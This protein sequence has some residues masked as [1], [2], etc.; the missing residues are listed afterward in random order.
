[1][2]SE[3]KKAKEQKES[4]ADCKISFF[5]T[6]P[7]YHWYCLSFQNRAFLP[8][9]LLKETWIDLALIS[10]TSERDECQQLL[11]WVEIW[12]S[13]TVF[14][15][16]EIMHRLFRIGLLILITEFYLFFWWG[17]TPIPCARRK[18]S[19]KANNRD[20]GPASGPKSDLTPPML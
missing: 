18:R 15:A 1:M 17:K 2:V 7:L 9:A 14:T 5:A 4:T 3:W 10:T 20:T 12:V 16:A 19:T 8:L 13:L 6:V 11:Y